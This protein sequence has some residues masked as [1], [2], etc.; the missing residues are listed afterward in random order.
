MVCTI[1]HVQHCLHFDIVQNKTVGPPRLMK[2]QIVR[3][4][5]YLRD[6]EVMIFVTLH[7]LLG[8]TFTYDG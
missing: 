6:F 1:L 5:K 4:T 2:P 3:S 8:F 7:L